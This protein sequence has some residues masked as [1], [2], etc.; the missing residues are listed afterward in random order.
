MSNKRIY[1]AARGQGKTKWL[2]QNIINTVKE[3]EYL[4]YLYVG[5]KNTYNYVCD[6]YLTE[7]GK[8]CPLMYVEQ[9]T[10]FVGLREDN[11]VCF[12][13]NIFDTNNIFEYI[14][15][16][17]NRNIPWYITIDDEDIVN[18]KEYN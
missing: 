6:R 8:H 13:D 3:N 11:A 9:A 16:I 2:I 4:N 7:T 12:T 10:D 15:I 1:I 5:D 14:N 18:K 17:K